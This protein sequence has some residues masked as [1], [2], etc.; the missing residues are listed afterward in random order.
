[1]SYLSSLT[2]LAEERFKLKAA[3]LPAIIV[4][5]V[6]IRLVEL[7]KESLWY[8]ELY[9]IWASL[10]PLDVLYREVPAS[11][12]P[13]F[14]YLVAHFWDQLGSGD[15]WYRTLSLGAGVAS[16]WFLYLLGKELFTR[17]VGL[18]GAAFAALSPLLV[19]YSRDA[20]DYAWLIAF[21]TLS[22]NLLVRSVRRGGRGNW[23]GFVLATLAALFTHYYAFI[24]VVGEVVLFLFITDRTREQIRAWLISLAALVFLLLPLTIFNRGATTTF[25]LQLPSTNTV[26]AIIVSPFFF[27][28]GYI[29]SQGSGA[30]L[31]APRVSNPIF[32]LLFVLLIV[33]LLIFSKPIITSLRG[34][35][36][37]G[38]LVCT[39]ILIAVPP[40][41]RAQNAAG[42]DLVLGA[43]LFFLL[44]ALVVTSAP[45]RLG[46]VA[47]VVVLAGLFGLTSAQFFL[48]HTDDWRDVMGTMQAEAYPGD[49][50]LC[51]PLHNC[52]VAQAIYHNDLPLL[53]GELRPWNNSR[54]VLQVVPG[55]QGYR[56]G[57]GPPENNPE[58]QGA[59]LAVALEDRLAGANGVWLVNETGTNGQMF[60]AGAVEKGLRRDWMLVSDHDYGTLDLK[61]YERRSAAGSPPPMR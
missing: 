43:P 56:G 10:L 44:V 24:L 19:W 53:G 23:A 5:A 9:T 34:R 55:W 45:R 60:D 50:L 12:H 32:L 25:F 33:G 42:R 41:V 52:V 31:I 58:Y 46:T 39:A 6:A 38:L 17:R 26:K 21:A 36:G 37:L 16:V 15:A 28:I 1:M 4:A 2:A 13:V 3:I 51:F 27:A 14:Y 11:G 49:R 59:A 40:L 48:T 18:W 47:G 57:Y 54:V 22:E 8:D 30:A 29:G 61:H 7:G 20:T 35:T